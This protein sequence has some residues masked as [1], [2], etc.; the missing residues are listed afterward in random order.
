MEDKLII[1]DDLSKFSS[2]SVKTRSS[3]EK[4]IFKIFGY[5]IMFYVMRLIF[6]IPIYIFSSEKISLFKLYNNRYTY[7]SPSYNDIWANFNE[8]FL[9]VFQNRDYL[10]KYMIIS[11]IVLS[12]LFILISNSPI[13]ILV[14]FFII[15]ISPYMVYNVCLPIISFLYVPLNFI[16][17]F[18][19]NCLPERIPIIQLWGI[20]GFIFGIIQV[21]RKSNKKA[22][23]TFLIILI[24]CFSITH[25]KF[26]IQNALPLKN[27]F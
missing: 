9:N 5:I 4:C 20:L 7:N 12:V 17:L 6:I 13:G 14:S 1:I 11:F 21:I 25:Y 10:I 8:A 26:C 2:N 19:D 18:I 23:I 22:I 16:C 3:M 15:I 24:I 27:F